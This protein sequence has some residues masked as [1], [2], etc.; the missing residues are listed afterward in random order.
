MDQPTSEYITHNGGIV[1]SHFYFSTNIIKTE[2]D[3]ILSCSV[4]SISYWELVKSF[5]KPAFRLP[6]L[7]CDK[8][9]SFQFRATQSSRDWVLS[10][11]GSNTWEARSQTPGGS[12]D[13]ISGCCCRVNSG[14]LCFGWL[15]LHPQGHFIICTFRCVFSLCLFPPNNRWLNSFQSWIQ[16]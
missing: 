2:T 14:F 7:K 10:S 15:E 5:K 12:G 3:N 9:V 11:L 6:G 4:K 8:I 13:T 16:N 1:P